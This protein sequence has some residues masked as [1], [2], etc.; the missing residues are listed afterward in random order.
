MKFERRSATQYTVRI[1][2]GL[3]IK[4]NVGSQF[5]TAE[6]HGQE[7]IFWTQGT[8]VEIDGVVYKGTCK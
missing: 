6:Y 2:N 3:P 5:A 8:S 1:G 7:L 4:L